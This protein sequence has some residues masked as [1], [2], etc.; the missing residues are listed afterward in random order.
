MKKKTTI[1]ALFLGSL[2]LTACSN[3][4][5]KAIAF[6]DLTPKLTQETKDLVMLGNARNPRA[7]YPD[8]TMLQQPILARKVND[9]YAQYPCDISWG[10]AIEGNRIYGIDTRGQLK[11]MEFAH[12][13]LVTIVTRDL[14]ARDKFLSASIIKD[15]D[16][17]YVSMDEELIVLKASNGRELVRKSFTSPID[18]YP[19]V[20]EQYVAIRTKDGDLLVFDQRWQAVFH[21]STPV[22]TISSTSGSSPFF[23]SGLLISDSRSGQILAA[24]LKAKA[25]LW[26]G[27]FDT[28]ID[29]SAPKGTRCQIVASDDVLYAAYSNHLDAIHLAS[30]KV[31]WSREFK[32]IQ[33]MSLAGNALFVTNNAKQVAAIKTDDGK[34][35]WAT[36]LDVS[37]ANKAPVQFQSPI[38]IQGDLMVVVD[39]GNM[40]RMNPLTGKSLD[41]IKVPK[42]VLHASVLNGRLTL[43]SQNKMMMF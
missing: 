6:A 12:G 13:R 15:G 33:S 14:K 20:G 34:V 42:G 39:D 18:G 36:H 24:E 29:T 31:L 16:K 41:V 27:Q 8:L 38:L 37:S 4:S 7:N 35:F 2:C 1:I 32:D 25:V 19:A 9:Q 11:I 22:D 40:Y 10:P 17:L 5:Q 30:G 21:N 28:K 26:Q 3:G 23:T 43:F